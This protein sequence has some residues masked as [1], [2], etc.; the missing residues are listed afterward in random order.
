MRA[1]QL[2]VSVLIACATVCVLLTGCWLNVPSVNK[3]G[4][5]AGG[6]PKMMSALDVLRTL[7]DRDATRA[8]MRDAGYTI[9]MTAWP[10]STYLYFGTIPED[11]S[12]IAAK[13]QMLYSYEALDRLEDME[14]THAYLTRDGALRMNIV[15]YTWHA[16]KWIPSPI[17]IHGFDFGEKSA[18]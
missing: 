2:T 6:H 5:V 4:T 17:P 13:F 10:H 1:R 12:H 14:V 9:S 11:D 15:Y 3:D 18:K 16:G 8:N 7:R